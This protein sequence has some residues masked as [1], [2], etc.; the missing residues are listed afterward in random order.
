M[1]SSFVNIL[2]FYE[3]L[4]LGGQQTQTYQ[5]LRR[6]SAKGHNTAWVHL[7]GDELKAQV[8][9]VASVHQIARHL[10]PRGYMKFPHRVLL[11]ANDIARIARQRKADVIVSGSGLGSLMCG[12]AA[13]RLGVKHYRLVGCSLVQVEK[14]LY[15]FYRAI[16]IDWLIDG[17][18]GWPAVL[19]ELRLK[20]VPSRKCIVMP[21][22]VDTE[23]FR[24]LDAVGRREERLRL[25]I[26]D[27]ELVIGWVGRIAA[28]MQVG[29][30]VRMAGE[31]YRRGVRG[32]RL[33]FVGGGPWEQALRAALHEQS[34]TPQAIFTGWVP[35]DRV[36]GLIN[37]MDIVPLLETD[38]HGG[39]I[40]RE[41]MACGRVALS[42]DGV[43]GTQR[44]FMVP[45]SA[46][47]VPPH[48]FTRSAADAVQAL[49]QRR[50]TLE[51]IGRSARAYAVHEMSFDGQI[52]VMLS[53]FQKRSD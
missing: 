27:D 44:R 24:P 5:L 16:G 35:M 53:A 28:N 11:I 25:G 15:R 8:E 4:N 37:A 32:V 48:D 52:D 45:G 31:L 40:V 41:A 9:Q 10:G 46:V 12:I 17:Y 42:V 6:L 19:E 49:M 43:S 1:G 50:E 13:R 20:G 39:S 22:A 51:D 7:F 14:T 30:T 34:L 29:N 3:S 21:S 47:L 2:F 33:L 26:A 36:N 38:P 18:F 23:L